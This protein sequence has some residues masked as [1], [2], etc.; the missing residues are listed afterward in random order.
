MWGNPKDTE[1]ISVDGGYYEATQN[2][3]MA[4]LRLRHPV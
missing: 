1:K 3:Y 2:L 4:P